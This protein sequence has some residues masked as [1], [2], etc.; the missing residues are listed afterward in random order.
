MRTAIAALD[1]GY[2]DRDRFGSRWIFS[3]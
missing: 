1:M 3:L 2:R